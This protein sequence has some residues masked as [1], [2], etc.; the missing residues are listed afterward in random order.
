[1]T[2]SI[3]RVVLDGN[4][5]RDPELAATPNGTS[6]CN[7]RLAVSD[8]V[9]DA[10][11]GQWH[12][13]ASYFDVD[14]FGMQGER[15]GQFLA[16]GRQVAV[17]GRLRWREW[18]TLD[19]QKREAVSIVADSVQFL[20]GRETDGATCAGRTAAAVAA[21]SGAAVA[22]AYDDDLPF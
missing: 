16:K 5:T 10:A 15:C 20:G 9:K 14:V 3:N 1:M 12:E 18:L 2:T 4:L 8:R 7:L 17:E 19:G 22:D 13:R 11:T 21:T 6:V